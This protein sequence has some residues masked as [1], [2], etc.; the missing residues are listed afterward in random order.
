[1]KCSKDTVNYS[2]DSKIRQ[3][4]LPF[5]SSIQKLTN[6]LNAIQSTSSKKSIDLDSTNKP[7]LGT[8]EQSSNLTFIE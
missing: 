3:R 1:M 5:S 7:S 4:I 8:N 6:N 2:I